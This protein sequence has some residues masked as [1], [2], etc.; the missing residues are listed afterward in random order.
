MKSRTIINNISDLYT[1]GIISLEQL[2]IISDLIKRV[3]NCEQINSKLMDK[4][5]SICHLG[6]ESL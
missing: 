4:Y 5:L 2:F 3:A 6:G 1:R